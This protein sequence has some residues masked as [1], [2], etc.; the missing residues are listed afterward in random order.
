MY[1]G[2]SIEELR[3]ELDSKQTTPEE[4]FEKANKLAHYFQ[5]DYNSFV[6][7]IDKCK[8]KDRESKIIGNDIVLQSQNPGEQ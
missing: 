7:I 5:D 6:T 4:L 8:Y 1:R 2:K 3:R